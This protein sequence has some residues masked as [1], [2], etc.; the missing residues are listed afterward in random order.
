MKLRLN[1]MINQSKFQVIKLKLRKSRFPNPNSIRLSQN[2]S[3]SQRL[4][5]MLPKR[6]KHRRSL[7][8][9]SSRWLRQWNRHNSKEA[10]PCKRRR[11]KLTYKRRTK[12]KHQ[13]K[14]VSWGPNN[15]LSKRHLLILSNKRRLSPKL[16]QIDKPPLLSQVPLKTTCKR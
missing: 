14:L 5:L 2:K 15:R 16:S 10:A 13:W 9:S 4:N 8:R 11:R 12:E 6:W 3:K 1:Y 7:K